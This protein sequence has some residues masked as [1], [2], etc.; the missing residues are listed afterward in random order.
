M[1]SDEILLI[2]GIAITLFAVGALAVH[3]LRAKLKM[4]RLEAQLNKEYGEK[5]TRR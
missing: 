4:T 3:V 1:I 2:I 5:H